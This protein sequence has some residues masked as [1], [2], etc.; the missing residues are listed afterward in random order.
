MTEMSLKDLQQQLQRQRQELEMLKKQQ[1]SVPQVGKEPVVGSVK[2]QSWFPTKAGNGV[3]VV[4]VGEPR[5]LMAFVPT[6][7]V[8]N[9]K[10]GK[11]YKVTLHTNKEGGKSLCVRIGSFARYFAVEKKAKQ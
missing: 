6:K 7:H 5:N 11:S 2:A 9:I 4:L 10:A 1:A 3:N 8:G